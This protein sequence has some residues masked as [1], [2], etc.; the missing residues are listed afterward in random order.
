[1]STEEIKAGATAIKR[2]VHQ[3]SNEM[4]PIAPLR[5]LGWNP[6]PYADAPAE[7]YTLSVSSSQE[8]ENT[9]TIQAQLSR[10][11]LEDFPGAVG[12]EKTENTLKRILEE[13][14]FVK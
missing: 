6:D 7:V 12:T 4:N 9:N 2:R 11:S 5:W 1:M 13:L 3:I 14:S 10:E 8:P